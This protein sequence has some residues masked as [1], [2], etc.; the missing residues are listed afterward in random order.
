MLSTLYFLYR[1]WPVVKYPGLDDEL[2]RV[3]RRPHRPTGVEAVAS[4]R[5]HRHSLVHPLRN[6]KRNDR[7]PRRVPEY[8]QGEMS[9]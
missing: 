6:P 1:H 7:R 4:R 9:W 3:T 8:P 5:R 2:Y